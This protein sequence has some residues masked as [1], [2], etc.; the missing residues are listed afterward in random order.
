[1]GLSEAYKANLR[2]VLHLKHLGIQV[3]STR[4]LEKKYSLEHYD[5]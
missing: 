1:M 3:P 5:S 4:E 2:L